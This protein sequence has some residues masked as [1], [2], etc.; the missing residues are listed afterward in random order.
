MLSRL[1]YLK[2]HANN[3]MLIILIHH[4][5]MPII[6]AYIINDYIIHCYHDFVYL[7]KYNKFILMF[8]MKIGLYVCSIIITKLFMHHPIIAT[9]EILS[10]KPEGNNFRRWQNQMRLTLNLISTIENDNPSSSRPTTRQSLT[11]EFVPTPKTPQEI[12]HHCL[13]RILGALSDRLYDIYY[14]ITSPKTL[15]DMLEKKYGLDDTGIKRLK[16]FD[17]NKFK[18][19]D[20]KSMNEQIHEFENLEQQLKTN[21]S[22]LDKTF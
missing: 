9:S 15:W 22:T 18:M 8:W 11:L 16:A 20:S 6:Q 13:H 21:R 3:L 7:L 5:I 14:T 10:G 2:N 1:C 12:Q 19:A 17:F 4:I